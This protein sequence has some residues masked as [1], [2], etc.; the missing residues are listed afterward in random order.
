MWILSLICTV[1]LTLLVVFSL[2][3]LGGFF[4]ESMRQ[5]N[6]G[7]N[8]NAYGQTKTFEEIREESRAHQDV[9]NMTGLYE[10]S[11]FSSDFDDYLKS[12]N[13]PEF[14]F[15]FIKNTTEHVEVLEPP[16][17]GKK[18]HIRHTCKLKKCSKY[19]CQQIIVRM[20]HSYYGD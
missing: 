4:D 3:W 13:I 7:N 17:E 20:F 9:I 2:F 15:P 19:I 11:Y 16:P 12:L 10:L 5:R 18:W 6:D 14:L 1:F 8:N